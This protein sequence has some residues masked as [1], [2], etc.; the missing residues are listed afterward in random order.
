MLVL[1]IETSCDET[2][3]A[4]VADGATILSDITLTQHLHR[5]YGGVVPELASREHV[6]TLA[7][8]VR[9]ALS[10]AGI[11]YHDLGGIA[12]TNGPGLVGALLVGLSFA[13]ALAYSLK[14]PLVGINHLEAHIFSVLLEHPDLQVPFLCLVVSGGHSNLYAVESLGKY[15]LIGSTRDDAAGE[16]FDKV[17]KLLGL[18]YP[19]GPAIDHAAK[20]G[21]PGFIRFPKARMKSGGY[22]FSFSGLK[23]AVALQVSKLREGELES[24]R[25]DIA[26]SF[27][28]AVVEALLDN[29]VA[30]A[31]EFHMTRIAVCGG[32]AGNSRLR[33]RLKSI[34]HL[35]GLGIFY[36]SVELCTDNAA[37]VAAAGNFRLENFS[38]DGLDL[39]AFPYLQLGG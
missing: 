29:T 25:A 16:A 21:D 13:K 7:P 24:R 2:A 9:E 31:E 36:P 23:T 22:D 28:E 19:G 34:A 8:V 27:Q 32:V 30:A 3:A 39:D 15:S 11:T 6:R 5:I 4:V 33:E 35:R 20:G 17:A 14:K 10:A 18:G 1:G 12:V 26:A 37:M 38:P